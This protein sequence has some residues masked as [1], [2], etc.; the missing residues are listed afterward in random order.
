M[1]SVDFYN[2]LHIDIHKRMEGFLSSFSGRSEM[3][4]CKAPPKPTHIVGWFLWTSLFFVLWKWLSVSHSP[5][6]HEKACLARAFRPAFGNFNFQWNYV[7]VR[8]P[9]SF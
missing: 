8:F 5:K 9:R 2:P 3:N 6:H 1:Q 4:E 7:F